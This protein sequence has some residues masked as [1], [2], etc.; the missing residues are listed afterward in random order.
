MKRI[1]LFGL[2]AMIPAALGT[3]PASAAGSLAVPL[4]TGDG[5]VLMVNVPIRSSDVPGGQTS[6][7]CA[8]GCHASSSR[9]RGAASCHT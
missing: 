4:C 1:A 8:K 2:I 5:Q 6:G 7:C 9:K 3:S